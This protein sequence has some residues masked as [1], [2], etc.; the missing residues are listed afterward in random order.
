[1]SNVDLENAQDPRWRPN[2]TV[3]AVITRGE[4]YL[5]VEEIDRD[6]GRTVFNQPAGHLE[7]GESLIAAVCREV[8]EETRWQVTVTGYLGVARFVASNGVTYLRHSFLAEPSREISSAALDDGIIA[9]HWMRFE[10]LQAR[11]DDLRSP[12]VLEV[13]ARHRAGLIAPLSLVMD[14]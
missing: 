1:M 9:C 8:L 2:A 6:S 13:I 3:A 12:L 4:R 10:E 11:S 7:S 14:L 5:I